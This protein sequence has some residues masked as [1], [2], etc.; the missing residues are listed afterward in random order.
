M[1]DAWKKVKKINSNKQNCPDPKLT[2]KGVVIGKLKSKT[3]KSNK[4]K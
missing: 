4:N 2:D 3:F 1:E